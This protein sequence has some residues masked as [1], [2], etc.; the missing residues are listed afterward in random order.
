MIRR[1]TGLS[2]DW[3]MQPKDGEL[4]LTEPQLFSLIEFF[5]DQAQ[6][7]RSS[8]RH[9]YSGCGYHYSDFNRESG[10]VVYRWRMN[11]MLEEQGSE[12]RLAREGT[13]RGRLVRSISGPVDSILDRDVL[14]RQESNP[15]DEIALAIEHFRERGASDF[16]KR[17]AVNALANHLEPRRLAIKDRLTKKDEGYLFDV[18]NNFAIRHRNDHQRDDYGPEF[19]DWLF[20]NYIAMIQLVDSLERRP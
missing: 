8:H 2:V 18:A 13:Q 12:Y 15:K 5:H 14:E 17:A 1:A 20:V 9:D 19:I 3:P 6:R 11:E 7:P 10:G 4:W 16:A